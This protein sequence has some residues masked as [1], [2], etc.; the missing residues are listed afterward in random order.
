MIFWGFRVHSVLSHVG[1]H[2]VS[3]GT[4][5]F[6]PWHRLSGRVGRALHQATCD[7]A[8][9]HSFRPGHDFAHTGNRLVEVGVGRRGRPRRVPPVPLVATCQ[10]APPDVLFLP[11]TSKTG[12]SRP[13]RLRSGV[14][15]APP[16]VAVGASR[17]DP[18]RSRKGTLGRED[19]ESLGPV[20][21][22]TSTHS[23]T[24]GDRCPSTSVYDMGGEGDSD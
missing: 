13:P 15:L 19:P 9:P 4:Y 2:G 22:E 14:P 3:T 6:H 1:C 10:V 16:R 7:F 11:P 5:P 23:P 17:L 8:P 18:T 24:A 12:A 20:L 21:P